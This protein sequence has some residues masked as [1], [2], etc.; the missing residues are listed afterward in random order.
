MRVRATITIKKDLL[1]QVDRLVDGTSIRSRS[2][3]MESLLSKILSDFRL[4]QALVL[5]GGRKSELLWNGRPKFLEKI[6]DKALLQTVMD[7]IH[8]FN[9]NNFLVYVD[10]NAEEIISGIR[11]KSPPYAVDFIEGD[12]P[13]GTISPLLKAKARLKDTF[14]VAYGDTITSINLNDMLSFHRKNKAIATV[15]LTTVSN[16]KKYGVATLEG[17]NIV[18]F[19][20]KP[21]KN[22]QS[23][24][25]NA[26]YFIFEPEIFKY[27]SRNMENIERDLFP[28]LAEKR[29]LFGY[30]FQGVYL[31]VNSREDLRK[32]EILL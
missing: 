28:K 22:V 25:V 7:S 17:N 10:S 15:A 13:T 32:A 19:V 9:V 1:E 11:A 5:A 16:P 30:P 27:V 12:R 21:T 14:L 6:N 26:G 24:L 2:Q 29:L 31:N 8:E 18:D 20:Q 3:A 4:S 23:Y